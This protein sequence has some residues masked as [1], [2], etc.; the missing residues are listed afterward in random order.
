[1][2]TAERAMRR[3]SDKKEGYIFEPYNGLE[4]DSEAEAV[5][6]YNLYSWEVGFGIRKGK[7]DENK[8]GW[9]RSRELV[10]QRQVLHSR[11]EVVLVLLTCI[12]HTINIFCTTLLYRVLTNEQS[13][14]QRD[15][16]VRQ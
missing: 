7:L 4:F 15:A 13:P 8:V 16:T 1:M 12:E 11:N 6:F 9:P 14:R 2:C 3:Y 5:E 10:C